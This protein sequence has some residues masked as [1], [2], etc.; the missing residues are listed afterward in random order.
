MKD[1]TQASLI[2]EKEWRDEQPDVDEMGDCSIKQEEHYSK[3]YLL[4]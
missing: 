4:F 2:W 1:W 3:S